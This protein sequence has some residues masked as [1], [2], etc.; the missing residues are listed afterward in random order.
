MISRTIYKPARRNTKNT[1]CMLNNNVRTARQQ[2]RYEAKL[3]R[4]ANKNK[5]GNRNGNK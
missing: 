1:S 2:R 5:E 3:N 4:Q